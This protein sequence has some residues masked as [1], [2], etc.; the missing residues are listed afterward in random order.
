[1]RHGGAGAREGLG[2]VCCVRG[3]RECVYSLW[4]ALPFSLR[5][6]TRRGSPTAKTSL[7]QGKRIKP[8]LRFDFRGPQEY[9]G[10]GLGG[11][12]PRV[13][14]SSSSTLSFPSTVSELLFPPPNRSQEPTPATLEAGFTWTATNPASG[15]D[16]LPSSAVP[17]RQAPPPS[18][19]QHKTMDN[20]PPFPAVPS[21]PSGSAA[22]PPPAGDANSLNGDARKREHGLF[23]SGSKFNRKPKLSNPSKADQ[24]PHTSSS[25]LSPSSSRLSPTSAPPTLPTFNDVVPLVVRGSKQAQLLG[26]GV[27]LVGS[28]RG[29]RG[30]RGAVGMED[31]WEGWGVRAPV[32]LGVVEPASPRSVGG[33][34]VIARWDYSDIVSLAL[35]STGWVGS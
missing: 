13:T 10:L 20:R 18:P 26:V 19:P 1:M 4:L 27:D 14:R 9:E 29:A 17:P 28:R 25:S 8:Q 32:P 34:E 31:D 11:D 12:L 22:W 35:G 23:S 7:I 30:S 21:P 33:G 6:V 5:W 3:A 15:Q 16:Q 24:H 2:R